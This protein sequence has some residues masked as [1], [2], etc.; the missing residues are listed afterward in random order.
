M[1]SKSIKAL[2]DEIARRIGTEKVQR[3]PEILTCYAFDATNQKALPLAVTF[4]RSRDDIRA[5]ASVCRDAGIQIVP[6]GA[7]TGFAGGT[8]PRG[9]TRS[10]TSTPRSRRRWCRRA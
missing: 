4:P 3:A 5:I 9:S 2:T 8:V 7:G 10:C 1:E 6:R